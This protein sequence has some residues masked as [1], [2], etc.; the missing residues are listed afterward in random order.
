MQTRDALWR[1]C[2]PAKNDM[3]MMMMMIDIIQNEPFHI[4]TKHIQRLEEITVHACARLFIMI[5]MT[6]YAFIIIQGHSCT[7]VITCMTAFLM[8]LTVLLSA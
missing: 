5:T 7:Y 2:V 6:N 8:Q 3:M 4:I 1:L